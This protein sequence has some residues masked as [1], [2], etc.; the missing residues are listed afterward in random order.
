M[1][2]NPE[3]TDLLKWSWS[4]LFATA[5]PMVEEEISRRL[6]AILAAD[7]T[8]YT[9]LMEADESRTLSAWWHARNQII[10]PLIAEND[11]RIVKHTEDGFLAEFST[12]TR[13]LECAV[14]L[15]LRRDAPDQ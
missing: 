5:L 3:F 12:A 13:A 15:P 2:Y 4:E 8:V 6:A 11:G 9:R 14:R 7:V 10:D 1:L